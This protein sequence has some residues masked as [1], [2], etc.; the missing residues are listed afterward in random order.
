MGSISHTA[1]RQSL[2]LQGYLKIYKSFDSTPIL[3]TEFPDAKLAE[4]LRA[5]NADDLIRDLAITGKFS[6][7]F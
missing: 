1:R 4:W 3:G 7:D 5:P 2:E 6:H